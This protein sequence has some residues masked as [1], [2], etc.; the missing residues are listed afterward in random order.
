MQDCMYFIYI[1]K[2]RNLYDFLI[3]LSKISLIYKILIIFIEQ[4]RSSLTNYLAFFVAQDSREQRNR[5]TDNGISCD[6]IRS[7]YIYQLKKQIKEPHIC[8]KIEIVRVY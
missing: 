6:H 4:V 3:I 7:L 5:R 8:Q 2:L 1:E